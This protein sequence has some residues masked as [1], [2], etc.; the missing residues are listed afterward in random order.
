MTRDLRLLMVEDSEADAHLLVRELRRGGY[1]VSFERVQTGPALRAALKHGGWDI[2]ISDCGMPG[3]NAMTALSITRAEAAD[4]PFIV[5]SGTL[6]EDDAVEVLR[7]GASDFLTKQRIARLIPAVDRELREK[8]MRDEG[9]QSQQRIRVTEERF[10]TLLESAPDGMVIVG[11][12][13][14][15]AFVNNQTETL[16]GYTR[17]ELVGQSIEVLVPAPLRAALRERRTSFFESPESEALAEGLEL[18]ALR[19]DGVEFPVEIRLSPARTAEGDV[20]TAAIRD[21]TARKHAEQAL[22]DAEA[23]LRQAQKMEAVGTLAGGIAHDFNNV[24]SVILSYTGFLTD[25][26]NPADPLR[27]DVEEISKAAGRAVQLTRQLLAFSRKQAFSPRVM[28]PNEIVGGLEGML[29]RVAGPDASFTLIPGRGVRHI[30]ADPGHI[31]QVVMNL[32]VNARDALQK[33]GQIRVETGGFELRD[34]RDP[35]CPGMRPGPYAVIGVSDTGIGMTP[36]IRGR[37]FE[38]FFTTKELGKGTGLGLA[39]VYGIVAQSAGFIEVES[40]PGKGTTFRVYFPVTTEKSG[41]EGSAPPPS[42]STG[43]QAGGTETILLVEDDAHVRVAVA[44]TLRRAGYTVIE[45]ENA[46]EALLACEQNP[47]PIDLMLTDVVM[48]RMT[49]RELAARLSQTRPEMKVVY[50]S[51]HVPASLLEQIEDASTI[52]EKPMT[53]AVLLGKVR[54]VIDRKTDDGT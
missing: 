31:E 48:P 15:I 9:R 39:V 12:D 46:G 40:A 18:T 26:L 5:L 42:L 29:R 45:S 21:V 51:G 54:E 38:P 27:T 34:G 52:I 22:R 43:V 24:L 17:L 2:V 20:V 50:M 8:A 30:L 3:F 16:F 4:L 28:D 32:V 33:G 10:R 41:S 53:A 19:K 25:A 23:Q 11:S 44:T 37:I 1:D 13:G 14:R 35:P 47:A 36:E 6:D 49:G 7:A